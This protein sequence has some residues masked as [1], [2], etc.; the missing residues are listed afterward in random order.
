M[1]LIHSSGRLV[2][3]YIGLSHTDRKPFKSSLLQ[4]PKPGYRPLTSSWDLRVTGANVVLRTFTANPSRLSVRTVK[5]AHKKSASPPRRQ[6]SIRSDRL[7][8]KDHSCIPKPTTS[9]RTPSVGTAPQLPHKP[10]VTS[11]SL[12]ALHIKSSFSPI[13]HKRARGIIQT[14]A[15]KSHIQPQGEESPTKRQY[16]RLVERT[17]DQMAA[18]QLQGWT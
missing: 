1:A 7:L 4:D 17:S 8:R 14:A 12:K 11:N 13:R 9:R 3:P 18:E 6:L 16:K 5:H 2:S 15:F 10:L